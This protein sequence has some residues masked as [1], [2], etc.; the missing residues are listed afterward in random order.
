MRVLQFALENPQNLYWPHNYDRRTVCY[1]GT[2]DNDTTNGWWAELD[3][4]NRGYLAAYTGKKV[5]DPAWELIRLAWASV[6][7][8]AITP[9]QDIMSLGGEARM[10][11][12][13]V[14]DGNWRWRFQPH[15][16]WPGVIDR[17]RG[18]TEL[19]NRLPW[20]ETKE[21]SQPRVG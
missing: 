1:T 5:E 19:Y 21:Q 14:A 9:L 7:E 6:A 20:V 17:L 12:P 10:N 2:H 11:R 3:A 18:F 8:I 4:T 15:Q 16:F 13:G